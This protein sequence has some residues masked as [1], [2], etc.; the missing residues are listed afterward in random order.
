MN[1]KLRKISDAIIQKSIKSVLPEEAVRKAM[2]EIQFQPG[3][4]I[5][6]SLL[7]AD[8]L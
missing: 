8:T 3:K 5:L 7:H 2:A 4:I 1:N 6:V